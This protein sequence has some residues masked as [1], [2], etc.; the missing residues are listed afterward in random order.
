M[1]QVIASDV[2][3]HKQETEMLLAA[4]ASMQ[5]AA[6]FS[7]ISATVTRY[8]T[9]VTAV[10]S[11]MNLLE[12]SVEVHKLYCAEYRRCQEMINSKRQQL[13]QIRSESCDGIAT[14]RQQMDQLKV[15]D[16]PV[17]LKIL[18]HVNYRKHICMRNFSIFSK[19]V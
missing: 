14:A 13:Q 19:S 15:I 9:L 12:K 1:L 17:S 2:A 4:T 11:R 10:D 16:Y 8:M 6:D 18:L 3:A 7:M 5:E